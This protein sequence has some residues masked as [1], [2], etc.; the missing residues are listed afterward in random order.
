MSPQKIHSKKKKI[1]G[2]HDRSLRSRTNIADQLEIPA[3]RIY[4]DAL[5]LPVKA[6]A[7]LILAESEYVNAAIKKNAIIRN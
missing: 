4:G 7:L 6:D 5:E 3:A 1:A 2:A